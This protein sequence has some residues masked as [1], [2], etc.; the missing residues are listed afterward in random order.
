MSVNKAGS[1]VQM[2]Q[3]ETTIST[4][5]QCANGIGET[6]YTKTHGEDDEIKVII[7]TTNTTLSL[8]TACRKALLGHVTA[9][10]YLRTSALIGFVNLPCFA[11]P[12]TVEIPTSPLHTP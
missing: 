1:V 3:V 7:R 9:A 5:A 6:V 4:A 11:G 10:L 12:K 2:T 8:R